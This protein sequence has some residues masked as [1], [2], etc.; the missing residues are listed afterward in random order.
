MA[1]QSNSFSIL[2][3]DVYRLLIWQHTT[4]YQTLRFAFA[5]HHELVYMQS[6]AI[7][8]LQILQNDTFHSNNI[9]RVATHRGKNIINYARKTISTYIQFFIR[10]ETTLDCNFRNIGQVIWAKLTRRVKAYSSSCSQ[11]IVVYLHPFRRNSLFCSQKSPKT[12]VK[13]IFLGFKVI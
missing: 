3:A 8:C 9:A 1:Q 11:V 5:L 4:S 10:A 6:T 2:H 7:G 13:S 12:H